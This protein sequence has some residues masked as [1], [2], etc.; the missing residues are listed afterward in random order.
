MKSFF[1]HLDTDLM[2][3]IPQS[4]QHQV[5]SNYLE[6]IQAKKFFYLGED[7]ENCEDNTSLKKA[8]T[9]KITCDG[10]LF[11]S[12]NQVNIDDLNFIKKLLQDY[13]LHFAYE[14]IILRDTK[15]LEYC[16][17]YFYVKSFL[18]K[19]SNNTKQDMVDFFKSYL[20]SKN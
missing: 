12:I 9:V 2:K 10:I 11:F 5:T 19:H 1:V 7:I 4:I 16:F 3:K 18:V 14:K 6:T 8:F 20:Y 13:E 17:S 15:D